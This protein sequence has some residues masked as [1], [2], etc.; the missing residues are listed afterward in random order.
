MILHNQPRAVS[1][2]TV[3]TVLSNDVTL[4]TIILAVSLSAD[5][6]ASC[7]DLPE[8]FFV[9]LIRSASADAT[10]F[11]AFISRT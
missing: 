2:S 9:A 1:S 6:D 11:T 3:F 4:V 5:I 10:S 7:D 8:A